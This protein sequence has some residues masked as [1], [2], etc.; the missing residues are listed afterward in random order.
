MRDVDEAERA[1]RRWRT[2]N[3]M[4]SVNQ[5]R[6]TKDRK[7][8]AQQSNTKRGGAWKREIHD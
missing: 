3:G 7:R 2:E 8:E 6:N 5:R 1:R 4:S